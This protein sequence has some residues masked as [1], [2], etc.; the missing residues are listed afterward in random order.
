MSGLKPVDNQ[1]KDKELNKKL[2]E[3]QLDTVKIGDKEIESHPGKDKKSDMSTDNKSI[4]IKKSKESKVWLK[5][6]NENSYTILT[7]N[8]LKN[9]DMYLPGVPEKIT[10]GDFFLGNLVYFNS[11]QCQMSY[12]YNFNAICNFNGGLAVP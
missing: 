2:S 11:N 7:L 12:F 9:R 3:D 5:T 10:L 8:Y 4:K 1:H 6:Y